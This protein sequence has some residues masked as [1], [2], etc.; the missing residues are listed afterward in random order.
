MNEKLHRITTEPIHGRAPIAFVKAL[1]L[2]SA[3][4]SL[5]Q[6]SE[7]DPD[8]IELLRAK[9]LEKA[10][11][12]RDPEQR[13]WAAT[14]ATV[15]VDLH[16]QGWK[17]V[18]K[19]NHL[20]G[21]RPESETTR[22][23]LRARFNARRYQQ[24]SEPAVTQ[25]I[26]GMEQSRVFRGTPVSIFS[27]L[28]DGRDLLQR[29]SKTSDL[30]TAIAPYLQFVNHTAKCEHTGL[31][32]Q[33][34]WRYVRHT[35][36]NPYESI[37][38]RS[39]QIIVRDGAARF[40]PII[41]IAALSS[42]AIRL[43]PRDRFIGWDTNDVVN[44]LI[45][46]PPD[47]T[48]AWV[49]QIVAQSFS[50]IYCLDFV[51]ENVLPANQQCWNSEHARSLHEIAADARATHH[52]L[53]NGQDYKESKTAA[54]RDVDWERQAEKPLFRSKRALELAG[55]IDIKLSLEERE[56]AVGKG[57]CSC[58]PLN[59]D[60]LSRVV[61]IARSKTVGTEI[62]DLTVC[63]AIAPYSHIAAGKLIALLATSPAAIAEYS[64]RYSN[65]PGVISSSIAGRPVTRR[66]NLCFV[67]TTS[68]YGKR[69]NQYDR[70][71]LPAEVIGGMPNTFIRFQHVR[72]PDS[73]RTKG[74]GTFHFSS[75][76]LRSLELFAV[77]QKGGWRV[78]NVFGEGTSPKLRGLREGLD[79]MGLNTGEL[80]IHGIEKCIYG[81]RLASNVAEYLLG[82][83]PEPKWL[84]DQSAID[85]G[86]SSIAKWWVH[87]WAA[88]RLANEDVIRSIRTETLVHPIRHS[89]RVKLP[90]KE[91]GQWS[92]FE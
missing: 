83:D 47:K 67:G 35:W 86:T 63:G 46:E 12:I 69:P 21:T 7:A 52:R 8:S 88:P 50:E 31:R 22:E 33:D 61:K 18:Y 92:L 28:R 53:M 26:E 76:T 44:R 3:A 17:I 30:S 80:L 13:Q 60:T 1:V 56:R 25:F 66:A 42:A 11:S 51:Q 73:V 39:L 14:L 79:K 43:G 23:S 87:R 84:F 48:L 20:L 89:G 85:V 36:A 68:L 29:L 55:L 57:S 37:P 32:L 10:N 71:S 15:I 9:I 40:H 65:S 75:T 91:S 5:A 90:A 4:Q 64:K 54:L 41:G 38:G 24:L 74:V 45:K 2:D 16:Q 19:N 78:N 34:I 70:I 62:A 6:L 72:D 82:F 27:L 58:E 59:V 49:K 77:S 81:V